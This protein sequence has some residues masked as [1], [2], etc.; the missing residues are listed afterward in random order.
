MH[1]SVEAMPDD[2]KIQAF[3]YG[4]LVLAGDLGN[5][6]LTDRMIIGPN[7]PAFHREPRPGTP[8]QAANR[9][10]APYLEVPTFHATG[11]EVKSSIKPT[12]N[13]STFRTILQNKPFTLLP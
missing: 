2:P 7:A 12:N 6:G 13:P 9:P 3:L 10:M 5:E 11:P 1:L 8:A 4:P